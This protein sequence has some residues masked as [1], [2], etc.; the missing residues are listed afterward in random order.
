MTLLT[1]IFTIAIVAWGAYE[2]H[3]TKWWVPD[4]VYVSWIAL[5]VGIYYL[6]PEDWE[7][8]RAYSFSG[9]IA[10]GM[11]WLFFSLGSRISKL[12]Y[13]RKLAA[14]PLREEFCTAAT[15]PSSLSFD[16][17]CHL[18]QP[19]CTRNRENTISGVYEQDDEHWD[20]RANFLP[21]GNWVLS[22]LDE[23][24]EEALR[25]KELI[26]IISQHELS[27]P[28]NLLDFDVS[29]FAVCQAGKLHI[30]P[31]STTAICKRLGL[32]S[33]EEESL[34]HDSDAPGTER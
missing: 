19:Y 26:T 18:L 32:L 15:F 12:L 33:P 1:I 34:F 5:L 16:K 27:I 9:A 24:A 30:Y 29:T 22:L 10:I 6:A 31:A 17:L 3:I 23:K 13:R 7:D 20:I 14:L 8:T 25:D 28:A 4:V 2:E 21:D 11:Y